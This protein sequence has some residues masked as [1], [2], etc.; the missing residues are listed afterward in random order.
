MIEIYAAQT[1]PHVAAGFG[2]WGANA[3]MMVRRVGGG[4]MD[5]WAMMAFPI[6]MVGVL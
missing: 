4:P 6:I 3:H 5:V 1:R 2:N